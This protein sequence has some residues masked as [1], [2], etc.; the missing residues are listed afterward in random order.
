MIMLGSFLRSGR[1]SERM[2]DTGP[3]LEDY[4]AGIAAGGVDE[5]AIAFIQKQVNRICCC[6]TDGD[7]GKR[8]L[9]R[10]NHS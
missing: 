7:Y 6:Q 5:A 8:L 3:A 10:M 1:A 9:R 2:G 4:K